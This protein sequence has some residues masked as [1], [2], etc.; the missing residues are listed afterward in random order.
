MDGA[1]SEWF[2]GQSVTSTLASC[3]CSTN[4]FPYIIAV[5]P[6]PPV[7]PPFSMLETFT[8]S[9][10]WSTQLF[11]TFIWHPRLSTLPICYFVPPRHICGI[12]LPP[13]S[14]RSSSLIDTQSQVLSAHLG[15]QCD[16]WQATDCCIPLLI[17][18][19]IWVDVPVLP[20]YLPTMHA[21][22]PVPL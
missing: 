5:A 4:T 1:A 17:V 9:F 12:V 22:T 2:S 14:S 15:C 7:L 13:R 6:T 11:S 21:Y 8:W 20:A 18:S 3:T 16:H 19:S 10:D